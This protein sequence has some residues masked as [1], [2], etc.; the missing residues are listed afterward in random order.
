MKCLDKECEYK[1]LNGGDEISDFY[2]CKYCGITV[3]R[4]QQECLIDEFEKEN[5]TDWTWFYV[6]V[7]YES[8]NIWLLFWS[9]RW[10]KWFL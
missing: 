7:N 10:I 5:S 9:T 3:E 6:E 1:E 2:Y 4:G 8:N